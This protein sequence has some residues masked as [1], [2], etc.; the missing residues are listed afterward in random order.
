MRSTI[1][2]TRVS[3]RLMVAFLASSLAAASGCRLTEPARDESAAAPPS[4]APVPD[5]PPNTQSDTP[6]KG[7]TEPARAAPASVQVAY[8]GQSL[9]PLVD[10]AR[11][12]VVS[13][14][15]TVKVKGGPASM[16]PGA[17]DSASLGSGFLIDTDGH[18]LTNDHILGQTGG[19]SGGQADDLLVV[20]ATPTG[21]RAVPARI[22][23]RAP[24][25][26]VALLAIDI[27]LPLAPIPLGDSSALH[28]G[29]WVVA[30]GNP[31]GREVTASAGIISST[32]GADIAP[33]LDAAPMRYRTFL[34]TDA[35]IHPGNSGGPLVDTT[36][37]VIGINVAASAR[38]T[39]LG[40]AVPID[41]V[42]DILPM[43]KRDGRFRQ[44]WLGVFIHPVEPAEAERRG[45]DAPRG[46]LVSEVVPGSPAAKAGVRAGDIILRFG[47]RDVDHRD[48]PWLAA[49]TGAGQRV[50]VVVLRDDREQA[51]S[52]VGELLP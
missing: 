3:A 31:F 30:L 5:A 45:M 1:N 46:A 38:G 9:G 4:P 16:Y 14:R 25:L 7:A 41:R 28:V 24:A 37:R 23:G 20:L 52:L 22:V 34:V 51:L 18:V 43:L 44:S 47:D 21:E 36:G 10:E 2:R 39:G 8:P 40:F 35:D 33:P 49:T 48:L 26:D 6:G 12:A 29:E 27:D 32:E 50:P 42:E 15:T 11:G 17:G 19:P 13:I